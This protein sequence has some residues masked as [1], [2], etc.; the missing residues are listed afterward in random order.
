[1][2]ALDALVAVSP[3]TAKI[4]Q[5]KERVAAR[6]LH[7]V[8]NGIPLRHFGPDTGA[9]ARARGELG[10]PQ[11][12][13][14]VGSVGRLAPEKDYPLLVRAMRPLL[15]DRIR[16]VIVG[17]GESRAEIER[18]VVPELA[19]FVTLTGARRDVPAFLAA[20]D[21]F[22]LPSRTEGLPLAIPEA[23]ASSLPVVATSVG[24]LP[25]SVPGD[26]G[27]LVPPA[28]EVSLRAALGAL[29]GDRARAR[30]MGD[31]AR[32]HAL[33]CFSIDRMVDAY[34]RIYRA[35]RREPRHV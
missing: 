19:K 22:A 3:E 17:E 11:D 21:V 35:N 31:A 23:M 10:I 14:V 32:R 12:A 34:E 29:L 15:G 4:A 16:L 5:S 24:G 33:A 28:D 25:S 30:A 27:V 20:F 2:R 8:P 26:C 7:V 1:V 18:A 13:L 9:R 6:R